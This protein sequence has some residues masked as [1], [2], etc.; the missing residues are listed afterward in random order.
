MVIPG[1]TVGDSVRGGCVL[2]YDETIYYESIDKKD[3]YERLTG[4]ST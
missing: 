3:R 2:W 4:K 1:N